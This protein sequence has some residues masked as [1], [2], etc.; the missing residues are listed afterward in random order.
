MG[1]LY[2]NSDFKCQRC[3]DAFELEKEGVLFDGY[4]VK[5]FSWID[6]KVTILKEG[7]DFEPTN[8]DINKINKWFES[9]SKYAN[10]RVYLT[11]KDLQDKQKSEQKKQWLSLCISVAG[12]LAVS[13]LNLLALYLKSV[14][15]QQLFGIC[16]GVI[17]IG[18]IFY[19]GRD[20][21]PRVFRDRRLW[22]A[23]KGCISQ[24]KESK[25]SLSLLYEFLLSAVISLI[26]LQAMIAMGYGLFI[27]HMVCMHHFHC[28]L[29]IAT[30]FYAKRYLRMHIGG[31]IKILN[32][33]ELQSPGIAK[34]GQRI[35]FTGI[36]KSPSAK[37]DTIR[38]NG[39]NIIEIRAGGTVKYG[40]KY[41]G[42][43]DI[44]IAHYD[45][46]ELQDVGKKELT[47]EEI[48]KLGKGGREALG[49]INKDETARL[50]NRMKL[51]NKHN[52]HASLQL[53]AM[54]LVAVIAPL[55]W[56]VFAS[57][58]GVA[59]GFDMA[60]SIILIACPCRDFVKHFCYYCALPGSVK[61]RGEGVY[62]ILDNLVS[63]PPQGGGFLDRLYALAGFSIRKINMGFD[64]SNTLQR[65][66][67]DGQKDW[68]IN[69]VR[70]EAYGALRALRKYVRN[71]GV[72]SGTDKAHEISI[73]EHNKRLG[74]KSFFTG[75]SARDKKDRI[76][77]DRVDVYVGDNQNDI[78]AGLNAKL[79]IVVEDKEA[80][81]DIYNPMRY[82]DI[83]MEN[84]LEPLPE[85][86]KAIEAAKK[87]SYIVGVLNVIYNIFALFLAC[88]GFFYLFGTLLSPVAASFIM[89]GSMAFNC[90]VAVFFTKLFRY[91]HCD[92]LA[93][94]CAIDEDLCLLEEKRVIEDVLGYAHESREHAET[95]KLAA[96]AA[97]R[98]PCGYKI[99]AAFGYAL[100]TTGILSH[101]EYTAR[102]RLDAIK[103]K[104]NFKVCSPIEE[105]SSSFGP[106]KE[107]S[108][109][110]VLSYISELNQACGFRLI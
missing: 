41:L 108:F 82:A 24:R 8:E 31:D 67:S 11:F 37:F 58:F 38:T 5:W 71:V 81:H 105:A 33:Q 91:L 102:Y 101:K 48:K 75:L 3:S 35:K 50:Q 59:A 26:L 63:A 88:G 47:K 109:S 85:L 103:T 7:K 106:K 53:M 32:E 16:C 60:F 73:A 107:A 92:S 77:W 15:L 46:D 61:L 23:L 90:L 25:V 40:W 52:W 66:E 87:A 55:C 39:D 54:L 94:I 17:C 6:S 51:F 18:I 34:K 45:N 42:E 13:I 62:D 110:S 10:Y 86:F 43:K 79:F 56:Y 99:F 76:I 89:L 69:K 95:A 70:P 80:A 12:F 74:L 96:I 21:W 93:D 64:W 97:K 29:M 4:S 19:L 27:G 84:T 72:Y 1:A 36:L 44:D 14:A 49:I 98:Y 83:T 2:L 9:H 68:D 22:G 100:T 78:L 30:S 20:I 104:W 57:S 28:P 65:D